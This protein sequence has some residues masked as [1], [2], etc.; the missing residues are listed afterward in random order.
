LDAPVLLALM[1]YGQ[2]AL[3]IQLYS[4]AFSLMSYLVSLFSD[5]FFFFFFS[6]PGILNGCTLIMRRKTYPSLINHHCMRL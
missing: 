4:A 2:G 1:P 5:L 6:F 3:R